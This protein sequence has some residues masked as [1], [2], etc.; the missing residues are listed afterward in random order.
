LAG[1][2][3]ARRPPQASRVSRRAVAV[4]AV[5]ALVPAAVYAV[6]GVVSDDAGSSPA[7]HATSTP[8]LTPIPAVTTPAPALTTPVAPTTTPVRPPK[9]PRLPRVAPDVPRRLL[10]AGLLDVGFD[11]SVEPTS[12]AFRAASTAEVA[13]WGSRGEPGNPAHDTVFVIG[14][15]LTRGVSA[16]DTL[17]AI[18]V[19]ARIVI[20][21]DSG[22]L[23]YTVRSVTRRSAAGLARTP[24]FTA[25]VPGRLV[26]V[27][28]GYDRSGSTTGRAVVVVA[29]IS[30]AHAR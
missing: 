17:P 20:R 22:D 25:K 4:A 27:G 10:S 21:T 6:H 18:K 13:R 29:E 1:N 2:H 19:G 3:R 15:S 12:G 11:D 8:T 23:T 24:T 5:I 7:A 14:K 16:F 26:A 9:R 30:A 28:L